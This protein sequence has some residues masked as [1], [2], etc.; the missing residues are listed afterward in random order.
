MGEGDKRGKK[1]MS[2]IYVSKLMANQ[3]KENLTTLCYYYY[4]LSRIV[5]TGVNV[6][7]TIYVD[8]RLKEDEDSN[9]TSKAH[10]L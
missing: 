1:A 4:L 5:P 3:L 8:G 9:G 10:G 6:Y 2:Q 7:I